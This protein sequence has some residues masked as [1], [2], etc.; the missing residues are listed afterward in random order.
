V[1]ARASQTCIPFNFHVRI[2]NV[3]GNGTDSCLEKV[4]ASESL[5]RG[6]GYERWLAYGRRD[7]VMFQV[8][9]ARCGVRV[10]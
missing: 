7:R 8:R 4:A 9:F 2:N 1:I 10:H 6:L 5:P 3:G